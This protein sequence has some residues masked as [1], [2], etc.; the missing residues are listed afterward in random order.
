VEP[1]EQILIDRER[2]Y[3]LSKDR[4]GNLYLEV[5]V[6]GFAMEEVV[7]P[8][9]LEETAAYEKSGKNYLDILALRVNKWRERISKGLSSSSLDLKRPACE[10]WCTSAARR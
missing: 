1:R 9:S 4:E 2:W 8:L 10:V 3:L 6:G 5:V 7:L